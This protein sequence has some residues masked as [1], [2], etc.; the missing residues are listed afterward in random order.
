MR[1]EI[2]GVPNAQNR[3]TYSNNEQLPPSLPN[4]KHPEISLD[5]SDIYIYINRGDRYDLLAN[6]YGDSKLWWII[7]RANANFSQDSL[8]PPLGSQIRIP[9][10]NR[11][12]SI[13]NAYEELN[14]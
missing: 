14:F 10:K 12:S 9:N 1:Y 6:Y 3:Q 13:L 2:S 7:S 5:F 4:I 11:I 8:I